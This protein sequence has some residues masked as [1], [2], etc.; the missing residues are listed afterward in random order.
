MFNHLDW[1][2][3]LLKDAGPVVN[4]QGCQHTEVVNLETIIYIDI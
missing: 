3:P 2:K 4:Q 1:F